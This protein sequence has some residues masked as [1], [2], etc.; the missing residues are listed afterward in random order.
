M[1][2]ELQSLLERVEK[3]TGPDREIDC[4]LRA[5]LDGYTVREESNQIIARCNAKPHDEYMIGAID[6]G[7][8]Q[9]NF[10]EWRCQTWEAPHATSS[11]DA[12]LA[13]VEEKLPGADW[14]LNSG[15]TRPNEP[16]YGAGINFRPT[17]DGAFVHVAESEH[18]PLALLAAL[19]RALI[20]QQKEVKA[21]G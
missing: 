1:T 10:T 11:L 6:P 3:A 18:A 9:R 20:A 13:L 15:K 19:L 21:A 2:S 5:V 17:P 7:R 8:E 14:M 16:R 12:V 4:V